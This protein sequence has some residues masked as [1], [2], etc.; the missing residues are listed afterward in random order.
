[1]KNE[2]VLYH[3]SPHIIKEPTWGKGNPY[4]DYGLGFYC[5]KEEELAKEWACSMETDGFA[6]KYK[7]E[8]SDLSIL[9]LSNGEYHILNWLAIL[10]ENRIFRVNSEI[11]NRG[12][13]YI[14]ETFL[15]S[16]EK[17]DVIC[18][19]RAD[20]SYFSFATAFLNN[21]ISLSQLE[22]AMYLGR[23]GEQVVLK[24]K[25]AFEKLQHLESKAVDKTIYYP[26]KMGRDA[27]AREE[28]QKEKNKIPAEKETYLIDIIRERWDNDDA[29]IQRILYK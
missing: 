26:K 9:N 22:K 8:L 6:N 1:M 13:E 14:R 12:K 29:R 24:S 2:I 16:Y 27:M 11:A 7:M 4:N 10:L 28:F 25:K 21:T 20:D 23:L 17:Y 3:G 5:T 19:Y 15:P 18:G